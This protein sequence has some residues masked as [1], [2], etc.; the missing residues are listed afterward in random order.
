VHIRARGREAC[1]GNM[2]LFDSY[3]QH[4]QRLSDLHVR[5]RHKCGYFSVVARANVGDSRH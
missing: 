1:Q 4:V 3:F 5:D 2:C